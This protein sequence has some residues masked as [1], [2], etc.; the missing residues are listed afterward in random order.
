MYVIKPSNTPENREEVSLG[1]LEKKLRNFQNVKNDFKDIISKNDTYL[2]KYKLYSYLFN[3]LQNQYILFDYLSLEHNPVSNSQQNLSQTMKLI[4]Q[5]LSNSVSNNGSTQTI[6]EGNQITFE[7]N[8]NS[9]KQELITIISEFK[10]YNPYDYT[11]NH[12][13]K[14]YVILHLLK[15]TK[16]ILSDLYHYQ[17][18]SQ[19]LKGN[20]VALNI[21]NNV[22]NEVNS[23]F[24]ISDID[25]NSYIV[26]SFLTADNI[27][28]MNY[29]I[30]NTSIIFKYYTLLI[31]TLLEL[32]EEQEQNG[33]KQLEHIV[34][35]NQYY[36][37]LGSYCYTDLEQIYDLEQELLLYYFNIF[38]LNKLNNYSLFEL[39]KLG[40]IRDYTELV[41]EEDKTNFNDFIEKI[42][43]NNIFDKINALFISK[44]NEIKEKL[45]EQQRL[46]EEEAAKKAEEEKVN[47][48]DEEPEEEKPEEENKEEENPEQKGGQ[49][50][51]LSSEDVSIKRILLQNLN[52][53][54]MEHQNYSDEDYQKYL[55]F[56]DYLLEQ[57]DEEDK[58]SFFYLSHFYYKNLIMSNVYDLIM[59]FKNAYY[60]TEKFM[61]KIED[62]DDLNKE[63]K[64]ENV[65]I[66]MIKIETEYNF[67]KYIY[68]YYGL[69][70]D[71]NYKIVDINDIMNVF[72]R[73]SDVEDEEEILSE[74]VKKEETN[75]TILKIGSIKFETPVL[76]QS[77]EVLGSVQQGGNTQIE[78]SEAFMNLINQIMLKNDRLLNL[79]FANLCKT[80]NDK[81]RL[82]IDDY[83]DKLFGFGFMVNDKSLCKKLRQ[84]IYPELKDNINELINQ[85]DVLN[86]INNLK[87]LLKTLLNILRNYIKIQIYMLYGYL[88][89]NNKEQS[90]EELFD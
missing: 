80:I 36:L 8:A 59:T 55:D 54:V 14:E 33:E 2:I 3:I 78:N 52:N 67:E 46:I 68:N 81:L 48:D 10:N 51:D 65:D 76:Q 23:D 89:W 32:L 82:I 22:F 19:K 38:I 27:G 7:F 9:T 6:K 66:S 37:V 13:E 16:I 1:G 18:I 28:F 50:I 75:K 85:M 26:F 83:D 12:N 34:K 88:Y 15:V 72:S 47:K 45:I 84:E 11:L 90:C 40:S 35:I 20:D 64:I 53:Y 73:I 58:K 61:E 41:K 60:V 39:Q 4:T 5:E 24:Y 63:I 79:D 87:E 29:F 49:L 30:H 44:V 56:K 62:D 21:L 43:K 17:N 57:S 69:D 74:E 77:S 71:E 86:E 31:E 25:E 42:A 70:N